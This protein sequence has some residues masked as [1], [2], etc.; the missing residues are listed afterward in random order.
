MNLFGWLKRNDQRP[1]SALL[2]WRAAWAAAHEGPAPADDDLRRRL[3]ELRATEP[4]VE[5]EEEMLDALDG[6][7]LA[8]RQLAADQLPIVETHHRVIGADRC[9]FTAPASL[10]S[11]QAQPS[12]RVLL[13]PS[14]AIFVGGGRSSATAWH[15]VRD[16]ARQE[17][18]VLLVRAD[19]SAAAHY[20]FNTFADAVVCALL[21]RRFG[22]P[23]RTG[24]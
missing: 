3:Q 2:Q 21:A 17:R 12:G 5:L 13:T 14:R 6:L 9:H 19:L 24:L 20:R 15:S 4:D 16:V 10:P 8:Q 7:R 22:Q 18:D 11:D 23:R 1:D